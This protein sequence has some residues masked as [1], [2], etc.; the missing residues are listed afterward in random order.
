MKKI[1]ILTL[2]GF[3]AFIR[4]EDAD[5]GNKR[6]NRAIKMM[7]KLNIT[8]GDETRY[9]IPPE[10][11]WKNL[12]KE[13]IKFEGTELLF[14]SKN[15]FSYTQD[16]EIICP[17]EIEF[18]KSE[19]EAILGV[20]FGMTISSMSNNID[21]LA[22]NRKVWKEGPGSICIVDPRFDEETQKIKIPNSEI[23]F[24]RNGLVVRISNYTVDCEIGKIAKLI[25]EQIILTS[26]KM[27]KELHDAQ[28]LS[29]GG[30]QWEMDKE[31]SVGD[32]AIDKP[33]VNA[34][35][36][37]TGTDKR[38][39]NNTIVIILLLAALLGI[40]GGTVYYIRNKN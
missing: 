9:S 36:S 18:A 39:N 40:G 38:T 15:V 33:S 12:V 25:D 31:E 1:M 17:V 7:E 6:N 34:D 32:A 5:V 10:E 13:N 3:M 20:C 28:Q 26:E 30:Y 14:Y 21:V 37:I 8:I 19:K 27:K 29:Q 24:I 11:I 4:A 22:K 16:G 2:I 23:T 35:D